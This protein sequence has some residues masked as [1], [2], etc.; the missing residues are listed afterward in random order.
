MPDVVGA[1]IEH[2]VAN[3]RQG[4]GCV[5]V[6]AAGNGN[7]AVSSDEWASHPKVIAVGASTDQ[8][9]RAPYSDF[10]PELALCAPSSGGAN[11][12]TTTSIGGYRS[13]FGGTSAAAPLVAGIA[14]VILS[15]APNLRW[16]EVREI[17]LR[18]ADRIDVANGQYGNDGHSVWYGHGRANAFRALHAIPV[19]DEVARGTDV[20]AHLP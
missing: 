5:I 12:I 17:L 18:S 20:E 8:D 11:G 14:A 9:V 2:A 16:H 7:E 10:G 6:W 3:G 15:V 4:K 19:L 13:D 1:A